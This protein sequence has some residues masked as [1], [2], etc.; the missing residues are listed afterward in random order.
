M[1]NQ[2]E[3]RGRP[4]FNGDLCVQRMAKSVK[5]QREER[6]RPIFNGD[7]CAQRM[8]KA[9][10]KPEI[11]A[12]AGDLTRL[13]VAFTYGADAVYIGGKTL[14]MRAKA[15]NFSRE[16]MAE[17]VR[18][19]HERGKKVYVAA[20][21][22]ARNTDFDELEDYLLF[23]QDINADAVLIS[24]V[25]ILRAKRAMDAK[26]AVGEADLSRATTGALGE[27]NVSRAGTCR[28]QPVFTKPETLCGSKK[29]TPDIHISTQAN[30]TNF[31]AAEFWRDMGAK[32]VVLARELSF[33]EIREIHQNVPDLEIE[34]FVH[35]AM[36][37]AYS[38]RCLISNFLSGSDANRGECRQP[39]RYEYDLI[40]RRSGAKFPVSQNSHG[41]HI[42][43]SKDL[44]MAEHLADLVAAGV[45]SLKIEGR[46]K[47]E[48]YVG[49]VT[50]VYRE[51]LDDFFDSPDLYAE[52]VP[53]YRAELEKVGNRGYTTGFFFGPP[54]AQSHDYTGEL[55]AT[56][57]DF[58]AIVE[59][60]DE[61]TGLAQIEQ[62]NK[63]SV[64]DKIEIL[65]AQGEN[66]SQ[67]VTHMYEANGTET[68]AE[69]HS[70]PH[71]MQKIHLRLDAPVKKFDMIRRAPSAQ[72]E[73]GACVG[74]G[75]FPR[76]RRPFSEA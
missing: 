25:G 21:I 43:N 68:G 19:A 59:G 63:F 2:R 15:T 17:G 28:G 8:A 32:R 36:C 65:R 35:G 75:A 73:P 45:S 40:E 37:M 34:V 42:F 56:S 29:R 22:C 12:P 10:K 64:G 52:K 30:I 18:F 11:L 3:E 76:S 27:A 61:K 9:M 47:T 31:A 74:G 41:T 1:K 24:D 33:G 67:T 53:Y 5:N 49:A 48:Y 6:G 60:Y 57:Q 4:I 13:K 20:N 46:M 14:S 38:G 50:K 51:A 72:W 71:P 16:E 70:A 39:C 54:D 23:L 55:Q 44:C 7:L 69:I 62:R 58:L 66:F 26:G